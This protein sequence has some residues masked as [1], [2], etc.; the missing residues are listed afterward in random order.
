MKR[1]IIGIAT[2]DI[3]SIGLEVSMKALHSL[4][5]SKSR[6]IIFRGPNPKKVCW[7]PLPKEKTA[8][9]YDIDSAL[10]EAHLT[11]SKYRFI[12]MESND[13]P[14][15]W[16]SI[17]AK[18]CLSQEISGMV[19]GPVSKKTF[20]DAGLDSIGHTPL[21]KKIC[22]SKE[23]YMGFFGRYFNVILLSGH[24]PISKIETHL[25]KSTLDFAFKKIG[26]WRK[27][28]PIEFAKKPLG[29]IGLNP[30][31]GE[32]GLIGQ[33]E[34]NVLNEI[35]SSNEFLRGPLVPDAAF[36]KE[37]WGKYSFFLALYHDQGLIPFKL[38][39]GHAGGAH[40]TVGIPIVRTSVDHGTAV[41]L[42]GKGIARFE[43]MRDAIKWCEILVNKR[44]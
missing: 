4:R 42:V 3:N 28:L 44:R 30:H 19:T 7:R 5:S 33:F 26:H 35:I 24:I 23:A 39:H 6:F 20:L 21:L 2:G 22:G 38:I 17:S 8:V 43:S 1:N 13:S 10:T 25:T 15:D 34:Q 14:A 12:E 37:N 41:D 16:V 29:V 32:N 40:V 31:N 11:K 18:L 9:V 36:S 27:S